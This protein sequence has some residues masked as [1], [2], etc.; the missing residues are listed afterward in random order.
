[1]IGLKIG[2]RK[3]KEN[4]SMHM[5]MIEQGVISQIKMEIKTEIWKIM[6]ETTA[7]TLIGAGKENTIWTLIEIGKWMESRVMIIL[8]ACLEISS[9]GNGMGKEPFFFACHLTPPRF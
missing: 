2:I 3:T 1:M 4:M 9:Q 5:F 7:G 8:P 6:S